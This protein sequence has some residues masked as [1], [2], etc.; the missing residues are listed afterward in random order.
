MAKMSVMRALLGLPK[1]VLIGLIA[2]VLFGMFVWP[3]PTCMDKTIAYLSH[4]PET[5]S[6]MKA[7]ADLSIP[8]AKYSR[9][10]PPAEPGQMGRPRRKEAPGE[11]SPVTPATTAATTTESPNTWWQEFGTWWTSSIDS[12]IGQSSSA[13]SP[14]AP[15]NVEPEK[16]GDD[17]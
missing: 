17:L 3:A 2:T 15:V 10:L 13:T 5:A 14:G 7:I 12:V 6:L 11:P 1:P 4:A 8:P 16:P 9:P